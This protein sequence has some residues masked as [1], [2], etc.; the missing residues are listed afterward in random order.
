MAE[1]RPRGKGGKFLDEKGHL[2]GVGKRFGSDEEHEAAEKE[3][4]RKKP[5]FVKSVRRGIKS[6]RSSKGKKK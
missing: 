4:G 1:K 3:P 6:L 2:K 5:G